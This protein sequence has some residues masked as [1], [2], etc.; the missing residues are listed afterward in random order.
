[1]PPMPAAIVGSRGYRRLDLVDRCVLW[2]DQ[3]TTVVSGG[4]DGV[5]RRAVYAAITRTAERGNAARRAFG[6]RALVFPAQWKIHGRRAGFIRNRLIVEKAARVF[7]FWD[8][9]SPG[10]AH[11]IQTARVVAPRPLMVVGPDGRRI[12][13]L[14]RS[15]A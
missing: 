6:M 14:E 13:Q 4:A 11:T 2:L 7:S 1:M 9:S 15:P 12:R 5:D 10:T 3:E 8:G